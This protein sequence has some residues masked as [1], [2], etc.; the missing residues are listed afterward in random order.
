M[1]QGPHEITRLLQEWRGGDQEALVELMPMVIDELRQIADG[2][3]AREPSGHTLQPTALVNEA[4]LK[5][6]TTE[7][8]DW[9]CRGQFFAVAARLMRQVLVDHARSRRAVK[10]GG[11]VHRTAVDFDHIAAESR[12]I[13]VLA[14]DEALQEM[15]RINPEGCRIVEMRYF[16]GLTIEEIAEVL[17]VSSST[18][19]RKWRTA[20]TWLNRELS[21]SAALSVASAGGDSR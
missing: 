4:Y 10:R 6:V 2:H 5:L 16:T 1:P 20:R 19:K 13:D 17:G 12:G 3:F 7:R 21:S 11:G 18:A 9:Q 8:I 14:L 15:K